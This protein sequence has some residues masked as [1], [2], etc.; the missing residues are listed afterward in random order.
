[1]DEWLPGGDIAVATAVLLLLVTVGVGGAAAVRGLV[2]RSSGRRD[3]GNR[4]NYTDPFL[5]AVGETIST[6]REKQDTLSRLHQVAEQRAEE[7]ETYSSLVLRSIPTGV[8]AFD[9]DLRVEGTN[10]AASVL[11]GAPPDQTIGRRCEDLFEEDGGLSNA[12]RDCLR[13]E[14]QGQ[15]RQFLVRRRDGT[16]LVLEARVATLGRSQRRGVLAVLTDMTEARALE[17]RLRLKESLAAAGEMA[18]GLSHQ[19]RN[20]LAALAG[21]GRLLRTKNDAPDEVDRLAGR[22][23][24]EVN[25]LEQITRDFLRFARPEELNVE[26]ADV[27]ELV[28]EV[29]N[30]LDEDLEAAHVRVEKRFRA[31]PVLASVDA[32]LFKEA[33]ANLVRNGVEAM[34][35]GGVL[36]V[37]VETSS[38]AGEALVTLADTGQGLAGRELKELLRPFYTTKEGGTGLGLSVVEKVVALHGGTLS[39]RDG[40]E[41]GAVFRVGMPLLSR[42]H[43]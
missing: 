10:P 26:P 42:E 17:R 23:Q 24:D 36:T 6:L 3:A 21:Y 19:V 32:V 35:T 7:A 41:G 13:E 39:C 12:L 31:G 5:R 37:C 22:I 4:G 34:P 15:P 33:L 43:A 1:M 20:S 2:K 30:T 25:E 29:L 27:T 38:S 9:A 11:L 14:G 18:A 28:S 16:A 40:S 8:I